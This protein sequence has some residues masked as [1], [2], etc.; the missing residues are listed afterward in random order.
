MDDL[1]ALFI[2]AGKDAEIVF[3]HT[4]S[5]VHIGKNKKIIKEMYDTNINGTQNIINICIKY[6]V[7]LL[8]VSSV[9]AITEPKC[10]SLTTEIKAFNPKKVVGKYAKTKAMASKLVMEAATKGLDA[11]LV[12][13]S[14]ITGPHDYSGTHMTQIIEDYSGGRIPAAT[15]GGY[16][17]V[18]VR[19]V[20]DGVLAAI[21]KGKSGD[22][23][24]LSNEYYSVK[25]MLDLLHELGVGKK[26][27]FKLP[28]LVARMGLPFLSI[29]FK[30]RRKRPLYTPYSLY[31]LRSNSNFSH[32]KA[33]NE[34]NYKPRTLEESLKDAI[35]FLGI[36]THE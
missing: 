15:S 26:V 18:D 7:R 11:V 22:C 31:T 3:I 12:H 34:L 30:L 32:A 8:Y 33:T 5:V 13:P 10:S 36:K 17:F 4:A 20:A 9:H 16:D 14:G 1:E 6:G 19:D 35:K 24:I 28:I 21:E 2:A 27:K 29:Y 23:Y 25:E